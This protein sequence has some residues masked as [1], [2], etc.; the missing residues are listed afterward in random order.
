ML[1]NNNCLS[2]WASMAFVNSRFSCFDGFYNRRIVVILVV[3]VCNDGHVHCV[4]LRADG[5]EFRERVSLKLYSPM[6]IYFYSPRDRCCNEKNFSRIAP[7]RLYP[8]PINRRKTSA[9]FLTESYLLTGTSGPN[10]WF[11]IVLRNKILN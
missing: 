1:Q 2:A 5:N 11:R 3:C 9:Q 8:V 6:E 10:K 4:W 7:M